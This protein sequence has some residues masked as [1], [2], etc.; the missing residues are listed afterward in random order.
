MHIIRQFEHHSLV[1]P[2][3]PVIILLPVNNLKTIVNLEPGGRR[4]PDL[5][6][7]NPVPVLQVPAGEEGEPGGLTNFLK[8][9]EKEEDEVEKGEDDE[10]KKRIIEKGDKMEG[11]RRDEED[12]QDSLV[13]EEGM[14]FKFPLVPLPLVSFLCSSCYKILSAQEKLNNHIVDMHKEPATCILC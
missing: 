14:M 12:M 2:V 1:I 4:R 8:K 13:V 9:E 5:Y 11:K 3:R 7:D 6:A 10:E